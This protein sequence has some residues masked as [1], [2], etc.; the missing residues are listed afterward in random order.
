M[1]NPEMDINKI[2]M[3]VAG[4]TNRVIECK[5]QPHDPNYSRAIGA[6]LVELTKPGALEQFHDLQKEKQL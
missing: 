1:L 3:S 2:R 5:K 6:L 4:A